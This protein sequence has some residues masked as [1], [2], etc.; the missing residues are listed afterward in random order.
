MF[1][2]HIFSISI[3]FSLYL[4]TLHDNELWFS[5]IMVSANHPNIN[6]NAFSD[7]EMERHISFRTEQGLY[8]SYFKQV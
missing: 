1:L 6:T 3:R 4:L 8:Y 5:E 2:K 7:Q